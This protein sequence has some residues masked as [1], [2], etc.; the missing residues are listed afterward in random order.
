MTTDDELTDLLRAW[1]AGRREVEERLVPLVYRELREV[2][3][4]HLRGERADH[5]LQPTDLVHETYLRLLGLERL[6]WKDR[7]HFYA[8]ASR[9]MRR[10]L[11]DHAR[12][13]DAEKRGFGWVRLPFETIAATLPVEEADLRAVDEALNDLAAFDP[14]KASIVEQRIFGG[15][16]MAEIATIS[17]FSERTVARH[18][19]IAK[20]WLSR[21]LRQ[22]EDHEA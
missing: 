8:M 21:Y 3:A 20:A 13:H 16:S 12:R 10:I 11:I 2:A 19:R 6:E 18:W 15:L 9:T 17:G 1:K 5:T 4:A 14:L 22:G 7:D